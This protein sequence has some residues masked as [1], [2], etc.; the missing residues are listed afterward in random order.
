MRGQTFAVEEED[1][2]FAKGFAGGAVEG[3]HLDH[4]VCELGGR[5]LTWAWV[6]SE[7]HVLLVQNK[8][9]KEISVLSSRPPMY[10]FLTKT[11]MTG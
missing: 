4:L 11:R 8:L 2:V 7:D 3:E 6:V 1:N 10:T 9:F 5:G